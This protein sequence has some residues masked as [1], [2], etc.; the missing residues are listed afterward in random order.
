MRSRSSPVL[1]EQAAKQVASAHLA[2]PILGGIQFGGWIRRF[3]AQRPV[4]AVLVVVLD[5]G[6][7][8]LCQ[9]PLPH[10][11]EPVQALDAHR[12][13]SALRVGVGVGRL[14]RRHQHLDTL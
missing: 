11:Q 12:T 10:D 7:Q 8:D 3:Q 13:N 5:V 1:V 9:M 2:L 4:R 14:H 6:A